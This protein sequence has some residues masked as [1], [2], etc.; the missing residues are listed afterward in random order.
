MKLSNEFLVMAAVGLTLGGA[1]AAYIIEVDTDGLDDGNLTFSPDF[2][3]GGDTTT[4][5]QSSAGSAVGLT[6]GDSIFGGNGTAMADSYVFT[7]SPDSQADNLALA[8]G[9]DLGAGNTAS[10]VLGGTPGIYS[11]YVTWPSSGNISGD[12]INFDVTTAGDSLSNSFNTNNTGDEWFLIGTVNYTSGPIT[13]TQSSTANT[14]VSMRS[15]GAL[16]EQ[17]TVPEPGVS[18]LLAASSL[19][20]FGLRRRQAIR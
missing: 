19:G 18:L 4:A 8:S 20:L 7:Y 13:L 2:S 15:A 16:F 9:D 10:G 5:S 14:F 3:F 6:G 1:N 17:T 12:P 11:I